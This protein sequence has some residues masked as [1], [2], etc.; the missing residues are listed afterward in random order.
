MLRVVHCGTGVTGIH[1]LRGII[2]HPELEL[3][4]LYVNSP[5]KVGKNAGEIAGSG[6]IG[7]TA[8]TDLEGLIALAPDCLS[9]MPTGM[10]REQEAAADMARFLNAGIDTVTCSLLN[11]NVPSEGPEELRIPLERACEAGGASLY[12]G[13]INP[14]SMNDVL[15]AYILSMMD[16]VEQIRCSEIAYLGH[17]RVITMLRD[18]MGF[19]QL[20]SYKAPVWDAS[21]RTTVKGATVRRLAQLMGKEVE[22]IT[23][24]HETAITEVDLDDSPIGPVP[25]G[26]VVAHRSQLSGIVDGRPLAVLENVSRIVV[27]AGPAHW[28]QQV[29]QTV[30][31]GY[32]VVSKGNPSFSC[33]I[34]LGR[35]DGIAGTLP[36]TA[37]RLVNAIPAVCEE[38]PG[39]VSPFDLPYYTSKNA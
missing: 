17:Y 6:A 31:T 15:P 2:N 23:Y 11:M 28:P 32:R 13:G 26:R 35:A 16:R 34:D 10:G 14:G 38:P 22:E 7:V 27:G 36:A 20:P 21:R 33:E 8:T 39:F 9:Y 30:G 18:H 37:M 24:E 19:G 29:G 25:A 5:E 3:V 1:G 4:G 12:F